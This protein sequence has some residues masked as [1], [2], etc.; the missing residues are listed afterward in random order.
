M[1]WKEER[2]GS[3]SN[4]WWT[5]GGVCQV[6]RGGVCRGDAYVK[7]PSCY[8]IFLVYRVFAPYGLSW[9]LRLLLLTQGARRTSLMCIG[10]QT[11]EGS[12]RYALEVTSPRKA[13]S[14]S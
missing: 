11:F 2:D 6:D 10:R 5:C 8:D 14:L 13:P 3:G 7:C 9:T 12:S 1:Q 4:S